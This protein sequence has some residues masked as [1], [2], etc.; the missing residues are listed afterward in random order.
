VVWAIRRGRVRLA[1]FDEPLGQSRENEKASDDEP[2]DA[3]EGGR[4]G[5]ALLGTGVFRLADVALFERLAGDRAQ[6]VDQRVLL[7]FA[8]QRHLQHL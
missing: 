4:T 3:D 1:R 2:G 7:G 5:H 8:G 6:P